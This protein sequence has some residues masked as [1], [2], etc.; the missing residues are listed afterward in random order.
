MSK[1]VVEKRNKGEEKWTLSLRRKKRN[2]TVPKNPPPEPPRVPRNSVSQPSPTL[3][4]TLKQNSPKSSPKNS[5]QSSPFMAR[6]LPQV[7]AAAPPPRMSRSISNASITSI[8]SVNS[9][10]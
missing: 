3:P 5:P 8:A 1:S 7:P 10:K 9:L 6:K 2:S 4:R